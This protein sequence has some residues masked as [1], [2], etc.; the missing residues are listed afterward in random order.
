[1]P[2]RFANHAGALNAPADIAFAIT[3]NDAADFSDTT[4]AIYVGSGGSMVAV[5][6]SGTEVTFSGLQGGS[7]VPIRVRRIKATGTTATALVGLL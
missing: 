6:S 3:P 5:L 1:M 4:R 2:D 7:I